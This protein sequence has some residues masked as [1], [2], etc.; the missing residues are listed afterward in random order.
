MYNVE[1]K[2]KLPQVI[3]TFMN[4]KTNIFINCKIANECSAVPEMK[5]L[6]S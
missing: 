5:H 1:R 3:I 2:V 4:I 6:I